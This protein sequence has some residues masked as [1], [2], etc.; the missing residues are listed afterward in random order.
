MEFESSC[1][2]VESKLASASALFGHLSRAE[3]IERVVQLE[4]ERQSRQPLEKSYVCRWANCGI[5]LSKL[6]QLITHIKENHVGSGKPAYHCEWSDCPRNQKPF[7]KR[8][9]M[10]NHMRTHTGE[11]PFV[12]TVQGC[13]KR[14]S[15]PDS[16]NTHIK[17]HSN[18]RPY[19]CPVRGCGKAYFHSRSLRKHGKS[20][21]TPM[22]ARKPLGSLPKRANN[23]VQ[24]TARR[25]YAMPRHVPDLRAIV[26][27]RAWP[28]TAQVSSTSSS[29]AYVFS[30]YC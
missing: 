26:A 13:D 4:K 28:N 22:V 8:H 19:A 9:K 14:F 25:R 6:N 2:P 15:R 12:C 29:S 1:Y 18:V 16:L 21:E 23:Q 5:H 17:T 7:M 11:R 30:D 24:K 20:H 3:L 27:P 10:H